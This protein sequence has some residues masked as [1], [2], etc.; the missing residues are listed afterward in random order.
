MNVDSGNA[1][2]T[3]AV[4]GAGLMGAGIAQV[5]AV[6]GYRVILRDLRAAELE[7]GLSVIDA[8]LSKFVDKDRLTKA[9]ASAARRRIVATDDL[10]A[11]AGAGIVVE[12]VFEDL[13]AKIQ[14]F[15]ALDGLVG[16][17]AILASN[18]S[19]LPITRLAAATSSPE[20]VVGTHFFSPV[21]LMKLCELIRG[22][23]T[24]DQTLATARHFAESLDKTCVVVNRDVPGFV[25]TRLLAALALEAARLVDAGVASAQD[26]DVA[27]KLGFGHAMGP[28]QTLDLT[29]LDIMVGAADIIAAEDDNQTFAVPELLRRMVA[30]GKL[31]RKSGSGFYD[32]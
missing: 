19:S 11:V 29:G 16:P 17:E 9:E 32:Y 31:G 26:V 12:A 23:H 14:L 4:I 2:E 24:S 7:R 13:D 5:A 22:E 21:P 6:S 8:S 10:D 30:S 1:T 27:C 3:V 25:T 28:L 18:T 20:R 15:A